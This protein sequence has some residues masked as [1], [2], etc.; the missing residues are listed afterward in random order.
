MSI[1]IYACL[2]IYFSLLHLASC[3]F[4]CF[5]FVPIFFCFRS[6]SPSRLLRD[7]PSLFLLFFLRFLPFRFISSSLLCLRFLCSSS[8][9]LVSCSPFFS[10]LLLVLS[11]FP[12]FSC[13]IS[14]YP[15]PLLFLSLLLQFSFAFLLFSS[16]YP[17]ST[18]FSSSSFLSYCLFLLFSPLSLLLLFLLFLVLPLFLFFVFSSSITCFFLYFCYHFLSLPSTSFFFFLLHPPLFLFLFS[19]SLGLIFFSVISF[20]FF[21]FLFCLLLS[22][23]ALRSSFSFLSASHFFLFLRLFLCFSDLSV[24]LVSLGFSIPFS[25][26]A[27]LLRQLVFLRFSS[28]VCWWFPFSGISLLP[29]LPHPLTPLVA[30]APFVFLLLRSPS[31]SFLRFLADT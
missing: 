18:F 7:F 12:A 23:R 22:S 31:A 8:S 24:V 21:R 17:L 11:F 14:L 25:P 20:S 4:L 3:S 9:R 28:V 29:I 2:Y 19:F 27:S 1:Y 15:Y 16:L 13:Y 5:P 26:S 30:F 6:L 10:L